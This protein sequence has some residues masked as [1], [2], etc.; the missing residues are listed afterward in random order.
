LALVTLLGLIW[1]LI[2]A[3]VAKEGDLDD[4]KDGA[5]VIEA[6]VTEG[7]L[8]ALNSLVPAGQQYFQ[9]SGEEGKRRIR[10]TFDQWAKVFV[11]SRT[12]AHEGDRHELSAAIRA[13]DTAAHS[14]QLRVQNH[15]RVLQWTA[16][17]MERIRLASRGK[18]SAQGV[19]VDDAGKPLNAVHF[20]AVKVVSK[21][22][23]GPDSIVV[24]DGLID[25]SFDVAVEG[26]T[27]IELTFEKR[28]YTKQTRYLRA[29]EDPERLRRAMTQHELGDEAAQL[30]QGIRVVM[31]KLG[32]RTHLAEVRGDL[33][34]LNDGS[35]T[36]ISVEPDP[37]SKPERPE[38]RNRTPLIVKDLEKAIKDYP[39]GVSIRAELDGDG[40]FTIQPSEMRP[41]FGTPTSVRLRMHDEDGG[42]IFVKTGRRLFAPSVT[43]MGRMPQAPEG[44]Y[45]NVLVLGQERLRETV[46]FY[47]KSNGHFGRG[48]ISAVDESSNG[49][50]I[51]LETMFS[52][53]PIKGS[54]N[55][56][57]RIE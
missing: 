18:I 9:V 54:R 13:I 49:Q 7:G 45:A 12:K 47:F 11:A 4:P 34:H 32:E 37:T 29:T 55:L 51:Q 36:V 41:E 44:P 16:N 8:A 15:P 56:E 30:V 46:Y 17:M 3:S 22:F 27:G 38:T 53:Q 57:T 14:K 35:G 6:E 43:E 28:G 33:R 31:E 26:A 2:P 39:F 48:Y 40:R 24:K 25:A 42:F 19:I 5:V 1:F 20:S 50:V 10:I 23:A 52:V 21:G